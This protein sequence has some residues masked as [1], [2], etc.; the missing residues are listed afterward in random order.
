MLRFWTFLVFIS[1][2]VNTSLTQVVPAFNSN[3]QNGCSPLVVNFTN[4]SQNATTYLWDFGNGIQSTLTN[5]STTYT[6]PGYYTVKL[7]AQNATDLDSIISVNYIQVLDLPTASFSIS[8]A[9]NCLNDNFFSFNN[10]SIGA[11]SYT[12]DFNDGNT[13]TSPNP[14]HQYSLTGS[15]N[16]TLVATNSSGCSHDTTLGPIDVFANPQ[17]SATV[18]TNL[19]CDS[20]AVIN[21][22]ATSNNST[23]SNWNWNTGDGNFSNTTQG[24]FSYQFNSTGVFPQTLIA[25]TTDGCVDSIAFDTIQI[26]SVQNYT[27]SADTNVGCPP[28]EV[29]F[30]IQP[31]L[32]IQQVLWNYGDGNNSISFP[33]STNNYTS[34]GNYAVGVT[35]TDNNGCIQQVN[36]LNNININSPP[37]GTAIV[38]N[39]VGCPP[40][41]VQFNIST[42]VSNTINLDFGENNANSSNLNPSYTYT[43]NG[44]YFPSLTITDNNGCE[45]MFNLD[46][47]QAGM[48]NIDFSASEVNGCAPMEVTFTNSA[49]TSVQF[50][51]DFGDSTYSSDPNPIHIYD[52]IGSFTVRMAAQDSNSCVDT[53]TKELY[54]NTLGE[55][56]TLPESDTIVTC[57]PYDFSPNASNIGMSYWNWDFGDGTYGSGPT[58]THTYSQPGTYVVKLNTDAPNGCMYNLVNYAYITVDDVD[59]DLN[60]N[61]NTACNVGS[62]IINNNS[63][64][65]VNH[66]WIMGD[67]ANITTPDISH[68]YNTSQSYMI[69]YQ[70]ESEIGC[71]INQSIPVIFQCDTNQ[72]PVDTNII[73]IVVPEPDTSLLN[74][75]TP[76]TDPN[77]GN[78]LSQNCGPTSINMNSP[79]SNAVSY[80]WDFGDGNTSNEENPFHFY[81]LAGTF[82]LT[83]YATYSNGDV[84]SLVINAFIDQYIFE[85]NINLNEINQC[86]QKEFQ[87][88]NTNPQSINWEWM[89]DSSLISTQSS[90]VITLALDD[91]VKPLRLK[92][93]DQYGCI[94]ETQRNLFLYQ[95]LALIEQDTFVCRGNSIN[96]ECSVIGDPIHTW[97]LGDGTIVNND[98]AFTHTYS[99]NGLFEITLNLNDNGCLRQIALDTI[100]VYQPNATFSPLNLSPICHMDSLL[101]VA[102]NNS[103]SSYNWSGASLLNS[104]DSVWLQFDNPGERQIS[105]SI[106][107]RGCTNQITTDTI[108]VNKANAG[109]SLDQL[110]G[111]LPIDVNFQDTSVN[112]VSW[113][114][115]FGDGNSSF[116]QNPSHQFL[117]FPSDSVNL[118]ITDINGCMDSVKSTIINQLN[119]EFIASDTLS[120]VHS[121]ITFTGLDNVVNNWLWDLG[122]GTSSTDSIVNHSYSSPGVYEVSLIVSDGQGCNDTVIKSNYIEIQLV[123][124][125]FSYTPP[126]SCPP[127]VTAFTNNS[128]NAT[129][130]YWNFG[131]N[132]SSIVTEPSHIY[133]NAGTYFVS[134]I[135]SNNIGCSD[136]LNYPDSLYVPGPQLNFSVDLITGCD[137]LTVQVF[138]SSMF[139]VNYSFDFGDGTIVQSSSATHTYNNIGNYLITLVGEDAAGCQSFLTLTDTIQVYPTPSIN[140]MLSDSDFCLNEV[141]TP[142][143][144]TTQADAHLWTYGLQSYSTSSPSITINQIGQNNIK[145]V[146]ENTAGG[147]VDSVEIGVIGHQI[148]DVSIINPGVICTNEG[149]IT[150]QSLN[151]SQL[152]TLNWIGNGVTNANQGIFDPSLLTVD[153]T[154]IHVTHDSIC[155]S[156]DS[157]YLIIDN[158]PDATILTNDTV[159]CYGSSILQPISLNSGGTWQGV[160]ADSVTGAIM[161]VLDT[162][163]YTY[164]YILSNLNCQ[165]TAAYSID[166]LHQNDASITHPG[167]ICDNVDTVTLSSTDPGGVWSGMQINTSTGTIDVNALGNGNYNYTYSI[168]GTCPDSDTLNLDIFEFIEASINVIP[169]Y[170]EGTDSVQITSNT[171]IGNW[172]GLQ[173]THLQNG[174]FLISN[175][176]DGTYEV[177]YTIT[178]N[179]PDSD[180]ASITLLPEPDI[181]VTV[182]QTLPCIG[183]QI[184]ISNQSANLANEDYA[185]FV[186]DS[187]YYP[188]FN[189]PFFLLDT[190]FYTISTSAVNLFGCRTD[191]IILDSVP[192][193]DTTAL[194]QASIIRSTVIENSK[195]YT[196]WNSV[197]QT[198]N[199]LLQSQVL[200][201]ENG[202][203]FQYIATVDSSTQFYIDDNVDVFNSEYEYIIVSR[204]CCQV[205]SSNSNYGS[206][207][208]LKYQRINDYETK[209]NWNFYQEW[210][211]GS[212]EYKVQ[213]LNEN[214]IWETISVTNSTTNEIIIDQ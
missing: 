130:Y 92:I 109:F 155:N 112:P 121:T 52:S 19:L 98:T 207:V 146:A 32:G 34:S 49:P 178:G 124:A 188:N 187:L 170:C 94:A 191:S 125:D 99:Q 42:S 59:I 174:L 65:V 87:F 210:L 57:S 184:D 122:D 193:Y 43:N 167:T 137:S 38:S 35:I 27:V 206:S 195:I 48:S 140:I 60:I 8:T 150:L 41:Q 13:N 204:N 197:T 22:S 90:D 69:N 101:F 200:R 114:W 39:N 132:T 86:N 127:I 75:G 80:F 72:M 91:S 135:A 147:C 73:E 198:L 131:D 31:N 211:N 7:I 45:A 30:N 81:A 61:I 67:G 108:T 24:N 183:Y 40:L 194:A 12:W 95:P 20:N 46:T 168:S 209:L 47:I 74:G 175:V 103:Y 105:L 212:K 192:V 79:F 214:N 82:D 157:L 138:D 120:C 5:P 151:M 56:V 85:A 166:I 143:N 145:Y 153:S 58:P 93:T 139:T 23:L 96:I 201:S 63:V 102:T 25:T 3:V 107:D 117:Q 104:G 110:N 62:V 163:F 141:I 129:N 205:N 21:F 154:L 9:S 144:T 44:T 133:A 50:Y 123:T 26:V 160:S 11:N 2:F 182:T 136:T 179:C 54:I 53:V 119:A 202:E 97:D 172:S 142:N 106:T 118:V 14:N 64:G 1:F 78:P 10:T 28:L 165:D 16:I 185:W 126:S 134:L 181:D 36:S 162:G 156:S 29:N 189:E 33:T 70:A 113:N 196:E 18:D 55:D 66:L 128:Q 180:T 158:P 149:L 116:L 177:Y 37:T 203:P 173:N 186:N 164:N 89:L 111:C 4:T 208:L 100:E 171:N 152:G 159:Y 176:N 88:S 68:T 161:A 115:S 76:L 15:F 51:W 71:V 6:N 169:N 199:P 84:D 213:K 77:T 190:G 83:H 17:L 148:P